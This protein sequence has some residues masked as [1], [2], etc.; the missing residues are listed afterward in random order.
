MLTTAWHQRSAD[1]LDA[2]YRFLDQG[3]SFLPT[4]PDKTPAIREWKHLTMRTPLGAEILDWFDEGILASHHATSRS[5]G[6]AFPGLFAWMPI[7]PMWPW[8]SAST[9]RKRT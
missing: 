6:A 1:L 5:L 8:S 4:N 2:A 9:C 7:R 3:F